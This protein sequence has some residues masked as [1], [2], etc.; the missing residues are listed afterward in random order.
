[1]SI[2]MHL[3]VLALACTLLIIMSGCSNNLSLPD[4][5]LSGEN[6]I[7]IPLTTTP[8]I[9]KKGDYWQLSKTNKGTLIV[10]VYHNGQIIKIFKVGRI[11]SKITTHIVYSS[12]S[13]FVKNPENG[14]KV[15]KTST[16]KVYNVPGKIEINHK[17]YI[18][19]GLRVYSDQESGIIY[20]Q[21]K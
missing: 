10:D 9:L 1:M 5:V 8:D 4:S 19:T 7:E 12:D 20:L 17:Q 2:K 14:R 15:A 13:Q 11:S 6:K 3:K 16:D 18:V 21:A